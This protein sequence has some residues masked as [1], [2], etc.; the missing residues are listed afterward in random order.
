MSVKG[1]RGKIPGKFHFRDSSQLADALL[2]QLLP[3]FAEIIGN[4]IVKAL[5]WIPTG[6]L[7]VIDILAYNFFISS[8]IPL[9]T[10]TVTDLDIQCHLFA[11]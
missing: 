5:E 11:V 1:F 6:F 4:A 2:T 8:A 3:I 10:T 9:A 7:P